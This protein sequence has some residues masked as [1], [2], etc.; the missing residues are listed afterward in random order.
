[1]NY[2]L[3][4]LIKIF[5]F[6]DMRYFLFILIIS[7]T[8]LS[9]SCEP[10]RRVTADKLFLVNPEGLPKYNLREYTQK[11]F[12]PY[13]LEEISGMS[14]VEDGTIACV[15]DE[16]GK[17]F[18]YNYY[19]KKIT[20]ALK[21]WKAG[22]YEGVEIVGDTAYVVNS[23]GNLLIFNHKGEEGNLNTKEINTPLG[24][25]NDVEGLGFDPAS[26][27]L[28]LIC[29]G[30]SDI[31]K[32]KISGQA[33]FEF[34]TEKSKLSKKPFFNITKK[35]IKDFLEK[36]KDNAYEE[37]RINFRPSGIALNPVDNNFYII[38]STG[39]LMLVVNRSGEIQASY[40]ISPSILGQPEGICF[41]PNGDMF[42]SS[43]GEGD[44]GY[45]LKFVMEK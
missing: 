33:A 3:P 23:K 40:P 32:K 35:G 34:N 44:K 30:D 17:L 31:D 43:E 45:I 1:M 42:I 18:F 22:D 24:K 28:L 25:K 37:K 15:Q 10:P 39:K 16:D 21:F 4:S 41:A 9:S 20:L 5:R 27:N 2:Q 7:S 26:G 13:V 38:A 6:A 36:H 8:V 14:F 19:N 29:K 11:F 12:L